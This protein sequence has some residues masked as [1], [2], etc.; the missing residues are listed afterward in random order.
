MSAP[1]FEYGKDGAVTLVVGVDGSTTS[2]N[3]LAY[4]I[5]AARRQQSRL[6]VV[7]VC[8]YP[9]GGLDPTG[10]LSSKILDSGEELAGWLRQAAGQAGLELGVDV[11]V[12]IRFGDP[13]KELLDAAD[14]ERAD[15]IIVGAS[16]G[17]AHRLAGAL[18]NRLQRRAV[19]PVTVVP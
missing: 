18:S 17:A 19:A 13:C 3:A 8:P 7:Y 6:L 5:G 9:A 15:Q 2:I 11:E 14:R 12:L 4:A 16:T 1:R 10:Y